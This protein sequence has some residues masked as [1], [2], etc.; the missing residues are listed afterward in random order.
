MNIISVKNL[1]K[2]YN[3]FTAVDNISFNV[4]EGDFFAFLGPNGAGKS[5]TINVLCTLLKF[6]DGDV[7]INGYKLGINDEKIRNSIG[8]VFQSSNL[9]SLLTVYENIKLRAAFYNISKEALNKRIDNISDVLGI[10][11]ILNKKYG[12]LSGGQKRR[13][14][15]A[16][17][18]INEPKILFLDE[19]TTGLDPQTRKK[20]WEFLENL[21]KEKKI[22][23]FLTTHYMEEATNADKI[24]IIDNGKLIEYN[25]PMKL[26]EKYASNIIKIV[27]KKESDIIKA[28]DKE[29]LEYIKRI[30]NIEVSVRSSIEALD[31]LNK[32]K[33]N[34]NSFEVIEGN[35]DQVFIH[36]TGKDIR[37]V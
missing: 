31:L 25:T 23:I 5:T 20:I 34:I 27:P 24:A 12:N 30:D 6:N 7:E 16:R 28:L 11:D 18:L 1:T 35:M 19:P 13:V 26:K 8:V 22:T 2:K 4:N 32:I 17:A 9:D 29:K 10:T 3:N 33:K 37:E 21:Q 15:I 36:L 14:D